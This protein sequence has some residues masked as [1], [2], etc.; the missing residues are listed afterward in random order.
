MVGDIWVSLIYL[1]VP[2]LGFLK[3]RCVFS[4]TWLWWSVVSH[5]IEGVGTCVNVVGM[6]FGSSQLRSP[7]FGKPSSQSC[8]NRYVFWCTCQL[9]SRL[10]STQALSD[11]LMSS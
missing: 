11:V 10:T 2:E 8:K 1:V 9:C 4:H 6:D 7:L 5:G 3:S